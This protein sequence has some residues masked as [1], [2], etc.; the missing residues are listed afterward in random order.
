M[1]QTTGVYQFTMSHLK[2]GVLFRDGADYIL[3]VNSIALGTLHH[4]VRVLGYAVMSNHLHLLLRGT[5]EDCISFYHFIMRRFAKMLS[6]KY[7]LNGIVRENDFHASEVTDRQMFLNELAYI[8]RNPYRARTASPY[9]YRWSSADVYF[10]PWLDLVRGTPFS[11]MKQ[12]EQRNVLGGH[13]TV[14]DTWEHHAGCILNRCFVDYGYVE[15]YL[16]DSLA[17][18]DKLRVYDLESTV[19]LSHGYSE[20]VKFSDAELQEKINA[21]CRYEY[22]VKSP[23]QMDRKSLLMLA[24]TL[25]RRFAASKGQ[26]R[27]LLGLEDYVLNQL[28]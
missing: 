16:E 21:L 14:P 6:R 20:T 4:A 17:L 18:F 26:I 15:K 13:Y 28:L 2:S 1:K 10:N 25:S 7:R 19:K 8:L 27:R 24:R 12:A 9:A 5:Y 11:G 22:H 23:H 3:A